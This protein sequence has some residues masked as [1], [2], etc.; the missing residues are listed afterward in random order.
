[1]TLFSSSL[2]KSSLLHLGLGILLV[3]S[4]DFH[5]PIEQQELQGL[6]QPI[7]AVAID[8]SALMEKMQQL[9]N[10]K[11]AEQKKEEDRIKALERRAAEAEKRRKAEEDRLKQAERDKNKQLEEK[12]KAD[13]AA[14]EARKRQEEE[15]R[16]AEELEKERKRKEAERREAEE[17]ARKA[18]EQREAEERALKEAERK[19]QEERE[20]AEQ[21]RIMQE[22]LEA[23]QAARAQRRSKQ[24][25][26]E[27][28]KYTA[29]ITNT[30][31]QNWIVDDSMKGTSCRLNIKLASNGLVVQVKV[32]EGS[33]NIC[34]AA[35]NAVLKAVTL[36]VPKEPDVF[37]E[38][39]NFNLTMSQ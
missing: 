28:Q 25:L 4:M 1:M 27:V 8:E 15:K 18:K 11:R 22:Q 20:R 21:E 9:E 3:V 12:R 14:A 33:S 5:Q 26:T 32:L 10:A 24:V 38:F 7:E 2:L 29:L 19:R 16:K 6:T 31:K 30:I 23:E 34:R 36:P 17:K 37:E 35:E 39:R 13:Q